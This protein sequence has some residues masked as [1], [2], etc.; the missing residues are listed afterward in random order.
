MILL[1]IGFLISMGAAI[2]LL[3]KCVAWSLRSLF[4]G[5]R[6]DFPFF[7]LRYC[8]AV[9]CVFGIMICTGTF[10]ALLVC[11]FNIVFGIGCGGCV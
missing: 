4:E 8:L 2:F 6:T 5:D 10:I 3:A 7:A 9:L 1:L 11:M